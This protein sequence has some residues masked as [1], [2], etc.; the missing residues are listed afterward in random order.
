MVLHNQSCGRGQLTLL[1]RGKLEARACACYAAIKKE[2]D[3]L[4]LGKIARR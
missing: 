2:F 3:G 1:S 4:R